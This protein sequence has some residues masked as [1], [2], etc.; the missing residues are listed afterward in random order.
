MSVDL[1]FKAFKKDKD[2]WEQVGD[3]KMLFF[4]QL[5]EID[6]EELEPYRITPELENVIN[7]SWQDYYVEYWGKI[8]AEDFKDFSEK[9]KTTNE[10]GRICISYEDALKASE[11]NYFLT[12]ITTGEE[13]ETVNIFYREINV[14]DDYSLFDKRGFETKLEKYSNAYKKA[15]I[16]NFKF[17]EHLN[18]LEYLK[19]P[20][21]EKDN[22]LQ[23]ASYI[24]EELNTL[25]R[26][27]RTCSFIIDYI[28]A[29]DYDGE[30]VILV[31]TC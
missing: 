23:E 12:A 13:I 14:Y 25:S 20:P 9:F 29:Y 10:N 5:K 26:Q 30:V 6:L 31:C 19:L 3:K 15:I 11:Q 7:N 17:E 27:I 18:S 8:K 24:E 4:N 16:T 22:V 2:K 1:M 21:E 28:E